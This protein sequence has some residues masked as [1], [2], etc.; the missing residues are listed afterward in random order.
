MGDEPQD[1][2]IRGAGWRAE[3][4][5]S[6]NEQAVE[7]AAIEL[8]EA[9]AASRSRVASVPLDIDL[10]ET[11][12]RAVQVRIVG[13]TENG[14]EVS[15]DGVPVEGLSEEFWLRQGETPVGEGDIAGRRDTVSTLHS[16]RLAGR[17]HSVRGASWR[18]QLSGRDHLTTRSR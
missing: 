1:R 11:S 16:G 10:D 5:P 14:V 13:L 7:D 6:R 15:V 9:R 3:L 8:P 12:V 18:R 17:E 4:I 2:R